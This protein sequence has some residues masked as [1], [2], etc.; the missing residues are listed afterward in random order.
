VASD[1]GVKSEDGATTY[2]P[3][4]AISS[5]S[6]MSATNRT[7]G[8]MHAAYSVPATATAPRDASGN[9]MLTASGSQSVLHQVNTARSGMTGMNKKPIPSGEVTVHPDGKLTVAS[10]NGRKFDLRPN[11]SLASFHAPGKGASFRSDGRLSSMH[12]GAMNINVG[13]RGQRTVVT[14]RLDHSRLVGFGGHSGYLERHVVHNGHTYFQRTYVLGER[15]VTYVYTTYSYHGMVMQHYVPGF[16]YAPAF[17]GW[18]YYPWDRPVPY[19]WGWAGTPWLAFYSAYFSPWNAY[20]SGANWLTDYYLGQTLAAGY[21]ADAAP[22][23]PGQPAS[24]AADAEAQAADGEAY[25]QADTPITPEVKQAIAD[26]VQ[27]Q[28]AYENAAATQPEQAATLS[29]LPQVMTPNHVFVVNQ[30]LNVVTADQQSCGLGAGGV[31]KLIATPADDSPTADLSVVSSRRY[32]CPAGVTVTVSLQDLQ[33]MQNH[34]RAQLDSGLK[35]LHDEQG[36]QGL[37]GAPNSAIGPPPRPSEALPEDNQNVQA[38]LTAQD[39]QATQAEFGMT[40]V[41]FAAGQ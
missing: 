36:Q 2:T 12:T 31:L 14:E 39:N 18:A 41:A 21:Q 22:A 25:A 10:T 4:A 13:P 19:S 5:Y 20:L 1:R 28:L 26:E 27:Q 15:R 32:D 30:D 40:Q 7:S 34:F 3:H 6:P 17:Y 8:G 23:D 38:M 37:P 9:S 16:Y 11:G 35:T 33:D 29:D 24:Y